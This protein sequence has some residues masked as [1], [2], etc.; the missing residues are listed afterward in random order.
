M[1]SAGGN[2]QG[3]SA[4]GGNAQG[5]NAQGG[6]AQG[7]GAQGGSGGVPAGCYDYGAFAPTTVSFSSDVMPIFASRCEGCHNDTAESTY[8]GSNAAVVYDKLLNGVPKQA[9]HLS[10]VVPNDPLVS[11]ML[12]KVEYTDPGGTCAVVQ[13]SEP[14]CDL[15]AP[16]SNMLPESEI[17]VLRSWIMTGAA[18]D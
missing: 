14:G 4:Q 15:Q 11:Y 6:N 3:G 8:Y 1:S 12:A 9:P 5:G 10:F 18:N 13:C 7:G 17:A 2:A 16:P